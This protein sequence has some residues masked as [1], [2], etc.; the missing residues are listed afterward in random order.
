[1][2]NDTTGGTNIS[3]K[4]RDL[5][6][7]YADAFRAAGIVPGFY[8]SL[9]DWQ[10]PQDESYKP[11]LFQHLDELATNYG[12][13]GVLWVDYSSA[14]TQGS[15]WG[16][17]SILENWRRKQPKAIY[18]NRFWNH[19]ENDCGDFFTP[20]KYVPPSGFPDRAFEVC[21]TINESFGFS[22]HDEK[23]KG[24]RE[25]AELLVDIVS[26]GGNLLLNVGPD[27]HG[28]IPEASAVALREVGRWLETHRLAIE[29]TN[30]SPFLK[31][32]FAG[33]CT[34][35]E[36]DGQHILYCHLFEWPKDGI[37]TLTGLE[38]PIQAIRMMDNP[39]S[40]LQWT[41]AGSGPSIKLPS[42]K[43]DALLP[44]V[45]ISLGTAAKVQN[46]PYPRQAADRSIEL[47][48]ADAMIASATG[49]PKAGIEDDHIGFWFSLN[50]SLWFSFLMD[51]PQSVVHTGGTAMQSAGTYEVW[52]EY[53]CKPQSGGLMEIRLL[54]QTLTHAVQATASWREFRN[55]MVG[56]IQISQPGLLAMHARPLRI[57]GEGLANVRKIT[58]KPV[59][60]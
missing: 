41:A 58:L 28:R 39:S 14:Q 57:D 43:P 59:T 5:V 53:A 44:V 45:E 54:D 49:E 32:P 25:I 47:S 3:P 29:G 56:K 31:T 23:W 19:L 30:A 18:N 34:V 9:I 26:K 20:E 16:T 36:R 13:V 4:G 8:Y 48:A 17:R 1:V 51:R 52:V 40:A 60:P 6:A 15:H 46:L 11:Y 12:D 10:H 55:T 22:Y 50:D 27:R 37:L 33:R 24:P 38:S 42:A 21:H 35:A 7:E 2:K